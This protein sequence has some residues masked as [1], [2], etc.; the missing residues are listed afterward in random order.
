MKNGKDRI[1][2]SKKMI[3]DGHVSVNEQ[4]VDDTEY[5]VTSGQ[6]IRWGCTRSSYGSKCCL[7]VP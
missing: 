7:R 1:R 3:E 5:P 6:Y 2:T 4:V